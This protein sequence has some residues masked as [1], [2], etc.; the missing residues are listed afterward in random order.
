MQQDK[1]N[2]LS[3]RPLGDDLVNTAR[4]QGV[5][6]DM[7]SFIETSVIRSVEE[8]QEIENAALLPATVVFTSMNAVDAVTMELDGLLP[9]WNIY[10]MG[11][12]TYRLVKN[13]FGEEV[14]AGTASSAAELAEKILEE[15]NTHEVIFFCGDKRRDELPELLRRNDIDVNEIVVYQ[16]FAVPHTISKSYHGI[17]FYSP[18]AVESFFQSNKL[19]PSTVLFAIGRTTAA[20][21]NKYSNNRVI[22]G[23]EPGKESLVYK[24]LEY[25]S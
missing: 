15:N 1:I 22:T 8:Q 3:T 24:M 10:C 7:L 23:D 6:I 19:S 18:S 4:Q 21:I 14:I 13:Y 2:I 20:A 12:T 9:S 5:L 25:Y 17:L 11:N 16:T